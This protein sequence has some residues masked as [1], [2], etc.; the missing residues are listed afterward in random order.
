MDSKNHIIYFLV[1]AYRPVDQFYCEVPRLLFDIC[2]DNSILSIPE[3]MDKNNATGNLT[4]SVMPKY[5]FS[6]HYCSFNMAIS[7]LY[8][9]RLRQIKFGMVL[10]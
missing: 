1:K 7:I 3:C 4:I 6:L 5:N 10:F 2:S 8:C 9:R